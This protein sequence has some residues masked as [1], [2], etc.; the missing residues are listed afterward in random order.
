MN[1]TERKF[2]EYYRVQK[3][4]KT[5]MFDIR[6]VMVLSG[7]TKE[8]CLDIMQNYKEYFKKFKGGK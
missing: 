3:S 5:N 8:E 1:I 6:M 2:E 4:G 7:L